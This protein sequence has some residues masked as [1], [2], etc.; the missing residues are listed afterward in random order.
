M[1]LRLILFLAHLLGVQ[2]TRHLLD[3]KPTEM[4]AKKGG[5]SPEAIEAANEEQRKG[6]KEIFAK[7]AVMYAALMFM[8]TTAEAL[9]TL[10]KAVEGYTNSADAD[11]R[12][13]STRLIL[14]LLVKFF[15]YKGTLEGRE[16]PKEPSPRLPKL[17]HWIGLMVPRLCDPVLGVRRAAVECIEQLLFVNHVLHSAHQNP[18]I[19][20]ATIEHP[21]ELLPIFD[22]RDK[23]DT[24]VLNEQFQL[25]HDVAHVLCKVVVADDLCELILS[26]LPGLWDPEINASAGVCVYLNALTSTRGPELG[27]AIPDLVDGITGALLKITHQKT[28][29]GTLHAL[30]N[31]ASHHLQ[32]VLDELMKP[33][34]L[35]HPEH[36]V[37]CF[38]GIAKDGALA[39]GA[40]AH[41]CDV[42]NNSVLYKDVPKAGRISQVCDVCVVLCP[43]LSGRSSAPRLERHC[44][45]GRHARRACCCRRSSRQV[46]AYCRLSPD[47]LW[48]LGGSEVPSPAACQ[49]ACGLGHQGTG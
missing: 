29:N 32:R 25:V 14:Y 4:A 13:R 39:V 48:H 35:P 43:H 11:H 5:P 18:N 34:T 38:Q 2:R 6:L 17:G 45:V 16:L 21:D 1:L 47:A 22:I 24:Q 15:E 7:L 36:I 31:L 33:P 40:F 28:L 37:R 19:V 8:N 9:C 30:K 3:L 10:I 49:R 23:I 42:L 46:R 27:D 44:S 12:E 26:S 20:V 41:V